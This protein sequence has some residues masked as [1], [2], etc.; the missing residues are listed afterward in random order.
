MKTKNLL[1]IIVL[2][3]TING[4]AQKNILFREAIF[5]KLE[6]KEIS[7]ISID[8]SLL[9][10][11][12]EKLVS[13]EIMGFKLE[14]FLS[15]MEQIDIF[16][17]QSTEA[18]QLM[19]KEISAFFKTY[20]IAFYVLLRIKDGSENVVFY[21]K[22]QGEVITNLL[23]YVDDEDDAEECIFIHIAGQFTSED[24]KQMTEKKTEKKK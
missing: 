24:L 7:Q 18:K 1:L 12:P 6:H 20:N 22:K 23:M 17:S 9:H 13:N 21:G 15:K 2:F 5:K 8:K 16:I 4:F 19:K 14:N 11:F 10:L 3:T